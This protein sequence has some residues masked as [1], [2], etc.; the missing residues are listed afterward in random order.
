MTLNSIFTKK[1]V[2]LH[3]LEQFLKKNW[4]MKSN[5]EILKW[6]NKI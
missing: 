1:K 5:R 3:N 4:Q 6:M 2:Q